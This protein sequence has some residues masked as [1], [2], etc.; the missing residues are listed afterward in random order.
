MAE[1]LYD[2]SKYYKTM[3]ANAEVRIDRSGIP[4]KSTATSA[5]ADGD[6]VSLDEVVTNNIRYY[7]G[8]VV[9]TMSDGSTVTIDAP[10]AGQFIYATII[11]STSGSPV[12]ET[13][14]IRPG[15]GIDDLVSA[16]IIGEWESGYRRPNDVLTSGPQSDTVEL[17]LVMKRQ[18]AK[19]IDNVTIGTVSSLVLTYIPRY[20]LMTDRSGERNEQ[21]F[22]WIADPKTYQMALAALGFR[23]TRDHSFKWISKY[24]RKDPKACYWFDDF[25]KSVDYVSG[26]CNANDMALEV[27]Y[28]DSSYA[29][30]VDV[31]DAT[32]ADYRKDRTAARE[33]H[34]K[35][36]KAVEDADIT[37]TDMTRSSTRYS[38]LGIEFDKFKK[39]VSRSPDAPIVDDI[40]GL[41]ENGG[42]GS[43]LIPNVSDAF[44]SVYHQRETIESAFNDSFSSVLEGLF[45][46]PI[47]GKVMRKLPSKYRTIMY[48]MYRRHMVSKEAMRNEFIL[49]LDQ[50]RLSLYDID[51]YDNDILYNGRAFSRYGGFVY[52]AYDAT[53]SD[54]EYASMSVDDQ[55]KARNRHLIRYK[56]DNPG[57]L[58][59]VGRGEY[60]RWLGVNRV[61][62]SIVFNGE[63]SIMPGVPV[64]S[65]QYAYD[66][67]IKS[68]QKTSEEIET[69]LV[70]WFNEWFNAMYGSD[71][72]SYEWYIYGEKNDEHG[73][74][75]SYRITVDG[76]VSDSPYYYLVDADSATKYRNVYKCY[77]K[78]GQKLVNSD[79]SVYEYNNYT[80]WR[81][82]NPDGSY[83]S[84]YRSRTKSTKAE[85][86]K[87]MFKWSVRP[88]SMYLDTCA[89]IIRQAAGMTLAVQGGV[90]TV[91]PVIDDVVPLDSSRT[92]PCV[93]WEE[94]GFPELA[95]DAGTKVEIPNYDKCM[96]AYEVDFDVSDDDMNMDYLVGQVINKAFPAAIAVA[97]FYASRYDI[98]D[99]D[100]DGI[101]VM[102][103]IDA[104][105]EE[106]SSFKTILDRIAHYQYFAGESVFTNKSWI[107]TGLEPRMEFRHM[108][109]RFMIPVELY[110]KVKRKYKRFGFTR[111]RMV[112][113][114][115]G[116]RWVEVRFIDTAIYGMYP[117][118]END[119][120]VEIPVNQTA[121]VETDGEYARFI[122]DSPIGGERAGEV[123]DAGTGLVSFNDVTVEMEVIDS[124]MLQCNLSEVADI[125]PSGNTVGIGSIRITPRPTVSDNALDKVR[126]VYDMPHLPYLDEIRYRA[127]NQY[128]PFDQSRFALQNRSG[129]EGT[130]QDGW[131]IFKESSK[132][133]DDL[134]KGMG[135]PS[136]VALLVSILKNEFG[137]NRV[138]L[139]ETSRSV[140]DQELQC[141]G[142]AE[143]TM[144]SWHNY[145]LAAKIMIYDVD[146][147]HAIKDDGDDFERLVD[148]AEAFTE[149]CR[150]A[151]LCKQPIN[152]VWCGRLAM[153][154][155]N[156]V[157]EFLPMG[158]SHK[159][160]PKFREEL[161][162]QRDPVETFGH[163]APQIHENLPLIDVA[164]FVRLVRAKMAANGSTL[165]ERAS[166]YD[167]K[168]LN[169]TSYGQLVMYFGMTGNIAGAQALISGEYVERYQNHV[170]MLFDTDHV[171]FV[172]EMLGDAYYRARIF[173]DS[174]G[175]GGAYVSLADGRIHI[176][177][178]DVKSA[179]DDRYSDNF[180]GERQTDPTMLERGKWVDGVFFLENPDG[181]DDFVSDRPV[182]SGYEVNAD[183]SVSVSGGDALVL[184]TLL[185]TQLKNEFD[186][187]RRKF[188]EYS[189]MLMY[190][191]FDDGPNASMADMLENEFGLIKAQ[192]LI[193]FDKM[194]AIAGKPESLSD[195]NEEEGGFLNA[196]GNGDRYDSIYEKVVSNALLSG[197]RK[198]SL[199]REHVQVKARA[200]G[201]SV[202]QIYRMV[203]NG[204]KVT[205]NDM[206]K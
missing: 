39:S 32:D 146:G 56:V 165:T 21:N 64:T 74:A 50:F 87:D 92:Y 190:D 69:Q 88:L 105:K 149:G 137:A 75:T 174:A 145:G 148:V 164:E 140:E 180:F 18:D 126:V 78:S 53:E 90:R 102:E 135:I 187:I 35:Y 128:G 40:S 38:D 109:A 11:D 192:D 178:S 42:N 157:W 22:D 108:P 93:V 124:D 23:G 203:N 54:P 20:Q 26:L 199:T 189:G 103:S 156:F 127:F 147:V 29:L 31:D 168:A 82:T 89:L 182:I 185:S 171:A 172:R 195:I 181:P 138:E 9:A 122:F 143:S 66:Y 62:S 204:R 14:V 152:V 113:S 41:Q 197:V 129:D 2:F 115:I 65:G 7:L 73:Y 123:L 184:H 205:A 110:R 19:S 4:L 30:P 166:M 36:V 37:R 196:D 121:S 106:Y 154:A 44:K 52:R 202:E 175:D 96:P 132:R 81:C 144:L 60:S 10:N 153:G 198:A 68:T 119:G 71:T 3:T 86:N 99:V 91:Y 85:L 72:V 48:D 24:G 158:V 46:L 57:T 94:Y 5:D 98:D 151:R 120:L 125:L 150:T 58:G 188:E 194:K 79:G 61:I 80:T 176:R 16:G 169:D 161:L 134:R 8:P 77:S 97:S 173:I 49:D 1:Q 116:V 133:L 206:L 27:T 59:P 130:R 186:A 155:N 142:G 45:G 34:L 95:N 55:L 201:L 117:Q 112:K 13:C 6:E 111:H 70:E 200:N 177:T 131:R 84:N 104:L 163:T 193:S 51:G 141:S 162:A 12:P 83:S 167:W 191:H 25:R 63:S 183:G 67:C 118:V 76:M 107:D 15:Y 33:K 28:Y 17:Q 139:V 101:S 136:T 43:A 170:D 159:D 100:S 47:A 179:Y 114:S 160:A